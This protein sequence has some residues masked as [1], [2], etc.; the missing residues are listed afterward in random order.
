M[1]SLC[2]DDMLECYEKYWD[3]YYYGK[4]FYNGVICYYLLVNFDE[5]FDE[6]MFN[7]CW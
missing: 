1:N 3:S 6:L 2:L 5:E 7:I 4:F